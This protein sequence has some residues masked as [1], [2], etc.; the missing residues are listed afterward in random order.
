MKFRN[1]NSAGAPQ[2]RSDDFSWKSGEGSVG[3]A[4]S[5][6]SRPAEHSESPLFPSRLRTLS[7]RVLAGTTAALVFMIGTLILSATPASAATP[8]EW[9]L[10]VTPSADYFLPGTETAVYTVEAENVGDEP[11]SDSEPITIQDTMPAGFSAEDV[12][13]ASEGVGFNLGSLL[14]STS[15]VECRFPGPFSNFFPEGVPKVTG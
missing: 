4:R 10:T 14:C 6:L 9:K 8:P 15:P 13:F 1:D 7:R 12:F 3:Q 5:V 11:T 2:S